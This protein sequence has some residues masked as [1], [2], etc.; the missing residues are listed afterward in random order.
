MKKTLLFLV[1]GLALFAVST[2]AEVENQDFGSEFG[3][4]TVDPVYEDNFTGQAKTSVRVRSLA[5]MDGSVVLT[6]LQSGEKVNVLY[7]TDG[8]YKVKT[9]NGTMGWVG[10]NYINE[11]NGEVTET[12]STPD[13][14]L[15]QKLKGYIVL[16]VEKKGEA[17]Y[18]NDEGYAFYLKDGDT[19]YE[20]MRKLGL[21]ISNE[22]WEKIV[23]NS[24]YNLRNKLKG[25]IILAV[26][27]N[28]EA[29][30]ISPKNLKVYY[31]QNGASAF[32][33]LRK[34]GLGI[35][36][37]DL[38]KLSKKEIT[39]YK[40]T[41]KKSSSSA[42]SNSANGSITLSTRVDGNKVY[43]SWSANGFTS[44]NGYKVV[45][46][47]KINPIY[48]GN[49]YHYLSDSSAKSDEWEIAKNG[50]YYFRVCEYLGGKCGVYSS[51]EKVVISSGANND[52]SISLSGEVNGDSVNL[53]W[54]LKEMTS[55]MGFKVVVSKSENPV[56]PGN[57]YHYFSDKN[58]RNDKWSDLSAGTYY[59][60][61]CEY[62][63]GKCGVYSNNF[64]AVVN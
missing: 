25:K 35:A 21:G 62:L 10:E 63:G 44:T 47:E 7:K 2:S 11:S 32:E 16:A 20:V 56:Y 27:K 28:G 14:N 60:R 12:T 45:M 57:E 51:N 29:Y 59:F 43:L 53:N 9:A 61:V 3:T 17:Y 34:E 41:V 8:W 42:S 22:N 55:S 31:L 40:K 26:E 48:P 18:L 39:E 52:G 24:D 46:S 54:S 50:T 15:T 4:C 58:I 19:A 33:V 5:C 37:K 6:T 23:N 49:E 64:Q 1:L 30:Y 36:N 38:L 13:S